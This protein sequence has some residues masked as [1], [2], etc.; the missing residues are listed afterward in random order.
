MKS[1]PDFVVYKLTLNAADVHFLQTFLYIN[2]PEF[3]LKNRKLAEHALGLYALV[4]ATVIRMRESF[5][6]SF[7]VDWHVT[8]GWCNVTNN[9]KL[10]DDGSPATRLTSLSPVRVTATGV[11]QLLSQ[12]TQCIDRQPHTVAVR[13]YSSKLNWKISL[14]EVDGGQVP[15]Y[16]KKLVYLLTNSTVQNVTIMTY[17]FSSSAT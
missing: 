7:T 9:V 12:N 13:L 2:C 11:Q 14:L 3:T 8:A 16:L 17:S 1:L 10:S 6:D 4:T 5:H 15:Q